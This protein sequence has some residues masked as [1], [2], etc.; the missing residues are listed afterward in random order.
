MR[1]I[2]DNVTSMPYGRIVGHIWPYRQNPALHP[3]VT[4]SSCVT[5]PCDPTDNDVTPDCNNN[6]MWFKPDKARYCR[7]RHRCNDVTH[8]TSMCE[9]TP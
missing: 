7:I 8:I 2:G 6:I 9:G 4:Y 5:S 3:L 1:Y